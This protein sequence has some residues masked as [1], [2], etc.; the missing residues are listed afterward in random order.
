MTWLGSV[1]SSLR[2][3]FQ[4]LKWPLLGLLACCFGIMLVEIAISDYNPEPEGPLE[5][6]VLLIGGTLF[7]FMGVLGYIVLP[8][9]LLI[10]LPWLLVAKVRARSRRR[11]TAD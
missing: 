9:L 7:I 3:A 1:L 11:E 6:M 5:Y 4:R 10:G 8:L 2:K